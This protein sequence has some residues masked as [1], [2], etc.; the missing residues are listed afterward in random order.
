M[1]KQNISDKKLLN[2]SPDSKSKNA[3]SRIGSSAI[4]SLKSKHF[5]FD[6]EQEGTGLPLYRDSQSFSDLMKSSDK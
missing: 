1:P 2:F 3:P 5:V 4:S 6:K